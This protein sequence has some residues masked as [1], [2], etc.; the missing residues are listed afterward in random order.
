MEA[1]G[2]LAESLPYRPAL[3]PLGCEVTLDEH[4]EFP[5]LGK[6]MRVESNSRQ[7]IAAAERSFG[8]WRRLDARYVEPEPPLVLKVVVHGGGLSENRTLQPV[9]RLH[10]DTFLAAWG[11]NVMMAQLDRGRALAFVTP[12]TLA[13]EPSLR[14]DVLEG[15]AL[16]LVT[17]L[18]QD[19]IPLHA[20]AVV[21][22]G[23]AVVLA[24]PSGAGKS[25][26]CYAAWRAGFRLLAEDGVYVSRSHGLRVWGNPGALH[27]LPDARGL[28]PEL[29]DL[30]LARQANGEWKLAVEVDQEAQGGPPFYADSVVLCYVERCDQQR[31]ELLPVSAAHITRELCRACAGDTGPFARFL[32]DLVNELAASGAFILRLGRDL[33]TAVEALRDL[34]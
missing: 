8:Q 16:T 22:G 31:T 20:G 24:A 13:N 25:T 2:K 28:F 12:V 32:P 6:P 21:R 7:V 27:L 15:L 34:T 19:R 30:P 14:Y 10:D 5:L 11:D 4:S 9:Y 3:D 26:L 23:R 29:R 33:G 18:H 1:S 17:W